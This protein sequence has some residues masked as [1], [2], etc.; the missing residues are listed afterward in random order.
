MEL[1]AL[2]KIFTFQKELLSNSRL[3]LIVQSSK[4]LFCEYKMKLIIKTLVYYFF[5][6]FIHF[7]WNYGK[8][9][10]KNNR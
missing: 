6:I 1:I 3:L 5:F 8:T 4:R 10:R 9:N 7:Q 2:R